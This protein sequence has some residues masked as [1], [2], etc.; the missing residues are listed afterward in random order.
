MSKYKECSTIANSNILI[1]SVTNTPYPTT[2]T[3]EYVGTSLAYTTAGWTAIRVDT[4]TP[5]RKN[6][7]KKLLILNKLM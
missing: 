4:T 6:E 2:C 1:G 7:T 3:M 5:N